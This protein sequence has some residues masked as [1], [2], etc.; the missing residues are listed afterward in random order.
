ML[1]SNRGRFDQM[2]E[3]TR[4]LVP[5]F[6]NYSVTVPEPSIL[7]LNLLLING[8]E[9]PADRASAGVRALIFYLTLAYRPDA[10]N[11]V[12]IEEPENGLHPRRLG[13]VINLLRLLT[14]EKPDGR[15]TQVIL[16]THSPYLLDHVD[17]DTDQVLVFQREEGGARTASPVD[18]DGLKSYM[19]DFMLGEVWQSVGEEGLIAP[20]K[21]DVVTA[22]AA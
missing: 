20:V 6:Q 12:L 5:G 11:V 10:P 17:L 1:R 9:I 8:L 15:R 18:A 19:D 7:S 22:V 16:T 4:E 2:E 14:E 3:R 21:E 13:E